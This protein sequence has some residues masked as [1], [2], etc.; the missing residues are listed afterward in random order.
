MKK[1]KLNINGMTTLKEVTNMIK[2][3]IDNGD[4]DSAKK[5]IDQLNKYLTQPQIWIEPSK[6]EEEKGVKPYPLLDTIP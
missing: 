3:T 5:Y 1:I 2:N 4:L 6:S